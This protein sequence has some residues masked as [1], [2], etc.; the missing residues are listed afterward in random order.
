MQ[1]TKANRL[2]VMVHQFYRR[3]HMLKAEIRAEMLARRIDTT[4][5]DEWEPAIT[6]EMRRANYDRWFKVWG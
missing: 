4:M 2:S 5:P 3:W 1:A 6:N